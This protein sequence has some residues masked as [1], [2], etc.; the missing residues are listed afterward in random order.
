MER[1]KRVIITMEQTNPRFA[2]IFQDDIMAD[3]ESH[4]DVVL[5]DLGRAFTTAELAE[6]SRDVDAIITAWGT[7]RIDMTVVNAAPRLKIIA[8]AAGSVKYLFAEE[9]WDAGITVTNAASAIATYVGEFALL[10]ALAMLRSLPKYTFGAPTDAWKDMACDGWETLIGKKVGL[11]GLGNTARSFLRYLAPFNCEIIAYDPYIAPERAAELGVKLVP[12]EE[13]LSSAKVISL[14]APITDETVNM[15][16]SENLKLIRDG[17][18]FINT[19]R[20]VLIDHDA[21]TE[22]LK[23]GRF[24]AVL[25][26]THP[27]PLPDDHPLRSMPNVV[28]TPHTAGPTIDGRRDLFR[29]VVDDLKLFWAGKPVRNLVTKEMLKTMA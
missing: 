8:H 10:A 25:D 28:V 9:I 22:E 6:R 2:D 16:N 11:I 23:T 24:K 27:E 29:C 12:L 18:V 4:A 17:A 5:N 13:L 14:H 7:P 3:L 19:A 21:L 15:L 1:K 26:V 20:G